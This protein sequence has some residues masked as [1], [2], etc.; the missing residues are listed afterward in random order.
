MPEHIR[1]EIMG[2]SLFVC[3]V[4]KEAYDNIVLPFRFCPSCGTKINER[5]HKNIVF[6]NISNKP[7]SK[8]C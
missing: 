8:K 1:T 4:K 3:F 6:K 5:R 7:R 2:I